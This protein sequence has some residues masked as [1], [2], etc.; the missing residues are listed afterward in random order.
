MQRRMINLLAVLLAAWTLV[1]DPDLL[2]LSKHEARAQ[3]RNG[4][5]PDVICGTEWTTLP[6][7]GISEE[8]RKAFSTPVANHEWDTVLTIRKADVRNVVFYPDTKG[9]EIVFRLQTGSA[10]RPTIFYSA[11]VTK[12]VYR[13]VLV[14]LD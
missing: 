13:A 6:L 3:D 11:L 4:R 9:G 12:Q 10:E 8:E 2:S 14:C 7:P 1:L 5:N